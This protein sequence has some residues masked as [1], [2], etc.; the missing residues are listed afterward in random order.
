MNPNHERERFRGLRVPRAPADLRQRVLRAVAEA[1]EQ[2]D[3]MTIWERVWES[4]AL[5]RA[6]VSVTLA[7]LVAHAGLTLISRTPAGRGDPR[8]VDRRLAR[9]TREL[10]DLPAVEISPRAAALVLGGSSRPE[11]TPRPDGS[12]PSGRY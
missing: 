3:P 4:R 11:K 1:M 6:W 10:L 9:E 5:G 7:L 8:S 12:R 2:E